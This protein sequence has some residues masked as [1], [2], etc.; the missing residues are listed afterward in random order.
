MTNETLW[1]Q[2]VNFSSEDRLTSKLIIARLAFMKLLDISITSCTIW[3][4]DRTIRR[5]L[6]S[7]EVTTHW[8]LK[9]LMHDINAMKTQFQQIQSSDQKYEGSKLAKSMAMKALTY[10]WNNKF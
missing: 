9:L 7:E 5:I 1:L 3:S 6:S 8:K 10:A 4:R 2:A